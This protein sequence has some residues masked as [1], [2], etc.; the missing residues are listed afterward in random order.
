MNYQE[1]KNKKIT[2]A[3]LKSFIRKADNLFVQEVS[4]FNG[5]TD[6]V[7]KSQSTEIKP[8]SKDDAIGS[9]GV[10][11]VGGGRDY[12][13]LVEMGNFIGIEVYNCCGS[14]ILLTQVN[15]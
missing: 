10:W 13:N 6:C 4:S 1:L 12:F 5:M 7:E 3:T 14:G 8:V 2:L 11:C 15:N 9:N